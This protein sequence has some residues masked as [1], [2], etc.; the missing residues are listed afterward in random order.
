MAEQWRRLKNPDLMRR[1]A[2]VAIV[3]GTLLN[4]INNYDVFF[5][6]ALGLAMAVKIGLTYMVPYGVSSYSQAFLT[7]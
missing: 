6:E 1:A 2:F 3:V 5:G 4:L 7:P